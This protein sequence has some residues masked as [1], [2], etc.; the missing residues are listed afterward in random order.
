[1]LHLP[2][3]RRGTVQRPGT[4]HIIRPIR[5]LQLV[6]IRGE[7]S[8]PLGERLTRAGARGVVRVGG[9]VG[10][11]AHHPGDANQLGLVGIAGV[12]EGGAHP[13]HVL[14]GGGVLFAV[15]CR[16]GWFGVF[17]V[18]LD[19]VGGVEDRTLGLKEGKISD[20][21]YRVVIHH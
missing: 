17:V 6:L 3:P 11:Q 21:C 14:L 1:M 2:I 12:V 18:L 19:A 5:L 9:V 7:S 10:G 20:N 4:M 16:F 15:D 8:C 13:D